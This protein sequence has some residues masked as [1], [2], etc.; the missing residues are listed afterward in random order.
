LRRST[1]VETPPARCLTRVQTCDP[2][3][4]HRSPGST[5]NTW[6]GIRA[7]PLR[8]LAGSRLARRAVRSPGAGIRDRCSRPEAAIDDRPL[9]PRAPPSE[10]LRLATARAFAVPS[11]PSISAC[12]RVRPAVGDCQALGPPV[13]AGRKVDH[14][15]RLK[16]GPPWGLGRTDRTG[17]KRLRAERGA[18]RRHGNRRIDQTRKREVSMATYVVLLD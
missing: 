10:G 17:D 15:R 12:S 7:R 4:P 3:G 16:S 14:L 9:H 13:K 18:K 11:Q 1:R 5:T 6:H 8:V 2:S